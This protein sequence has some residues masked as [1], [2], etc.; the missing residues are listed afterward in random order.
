MFK[1]IWE[2]LPPAL[3]YYLTH[4]VTVVFYYEIWRSLAIPA[5]FKSHYAQLGNRPTI[6]MA[7]FNNLTNAG[8]PNQGS[9]TLGAK[10]FWCVP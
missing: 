8:F 5:S 9:R 10:P 6:G 7:K 4:I 1:F 3:Y 2:S